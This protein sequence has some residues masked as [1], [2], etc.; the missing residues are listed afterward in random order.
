MNAKNITPTE[1]EDEQGAC[2]RCRL[3][4]GY[5][6]FG[7]DRD[8]RDVVSL[9]TRDNISVS[10]GDV[11]IGPQERNFDEDFNHATSFQVKAVWD[12]SELVF[13][14][15]ELS[16]STVARGWV[17]ER[18]FPVMRAILLTATIFNYWI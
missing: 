14:R 16:V 9:T 4:I 13:H 7:F 12:L 15:D 8:L 11:T 1:E 5:F 10:G 3:R 17:R 18:Q 6:F 2:V